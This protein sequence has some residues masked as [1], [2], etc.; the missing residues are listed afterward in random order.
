MFYSFDAYDTFTEIFASNFILCPIFRQIQK[1]LYY[2]FVLIS[3]DQN[4]SKYNTL[5]SPM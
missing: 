5:L 2:T 3:V 4:K 1:Y